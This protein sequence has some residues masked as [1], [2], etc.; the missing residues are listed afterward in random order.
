MGP[1]RVAMRSFNDSVVGRRGF[2]PPKAFR[3]LIYSQLPLAAW[4]PPRSSPSVGRTPP[5][6]NQRRSA[7][8][9]SRQDLPSHQVEGVQI[10]LVI[11]LQHEAADPFLGQVAHLP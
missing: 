6:V 1:A 8:H 10:L 9:E 11:E 7:S 2:E 5:P 4:V 3:Q